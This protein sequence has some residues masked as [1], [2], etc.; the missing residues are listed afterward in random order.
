MIICS[1]VFGF[2]I[3]TFTILQYCKEPPAVI[4]NILRLRLVIAPPLLITIIVLLF[5]VG[6]V[7]GAQGAHR[8]LKPQYKLIQSDEEPIPK[9]KRS[10]E[11]SSNSIILNMADNIAFN[12]ED[13]ELA[14]QA[15]SLL[16]I[17]EEELDMTDLL[18]NDS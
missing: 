2:V 5:V 9:R 3:S 6:L 4:V 10:T 12:D 1:V 11:R 18:L 14:K 13:D 8:I 17:T 16:S 15:V 7:L